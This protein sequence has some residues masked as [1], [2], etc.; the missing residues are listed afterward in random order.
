MNVNEVVGWTAGSS[1]VFQLVAKLSTALLKRR[2]PSWNIPNE[3][4]A[5]VTGGMFSRYI[6][7]TINAALSSSWGIYKLSQGNRR[8]KDPSGNNKSVVLINGYLLAD[9]LLADDWTTDFSNLFHHGI[10]ISCISGLLLGN[11]AETFM[12]DVELME[13]STVL[14]N[15][16]WFLRTF[17]KTDTMLYKIVS[18]MFISLFFITRVVW[19]PYILLKVRSQ[20]PEEWGKLNLFMKIA[21]PSLWV[22][23]VYWFRKIIALTKKAF[24]PSRPIRS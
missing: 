9:F 4:K 19:Y 6:I 17:N 20:Y 16:M 3:T 15:I 23:Q 7:S 5:I 18:I 10:G 22:L 1:V 11:I 13:S 8:W 14:L 21:L 12:P 24:K 2:V